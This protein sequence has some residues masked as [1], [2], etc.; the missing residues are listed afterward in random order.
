MD[1]SGKNIEDEYDGFFIPCYSKPRNR[2]YRVNVDFLNRQFYN[3][4]NSRFIYSLF[5]SVVVTFDLNDS[6]NS[7]SKLI[8]LLIVKK[9]YI[10]YLKI[11]YLMKENKKSISNLSRFICSGYYKERTDKN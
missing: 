5:L 3:Y 8:W 1:S 11:R 4:S 6:H 10:N 9:E 7:Y 2:D